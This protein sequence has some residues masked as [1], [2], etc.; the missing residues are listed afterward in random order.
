MTFDQHI[1]ALQA[2]AVGMN[3]S[4]RAMLAAKLKT[5]VARL[6]PAFA[7]KDGKLD[8]TKV[9]AGLMGVSVGLLSQADK[10]LRLGS[11]Y[12]ID[13]V[14]SGKISVS[15]AAMLCS[16]EPHRPR[17]RELIRCWRQCSELEQHEF[18]E[19]YSCNFSDNSKAGA[20]LGSA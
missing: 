13:Q 14:K 2:Q 7:R 16:S 5:D 15:K 10:V 12:L 19:I 9:A 3:P 20:S 17:L 18:I 4:Q 11:D 1:K 8:S 6:K